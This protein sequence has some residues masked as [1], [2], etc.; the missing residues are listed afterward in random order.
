MWLEL[1]WNHCL[2]IA[3]H[4]P[5][6]IN[7]SRGSEKVLYLF[8]V[9]WNQ[10]WRTWPLTGLDIIDFLFRSTSCE[11]T[12]HVWNVPLW[13]LKK[14]CWLSERFEVQDWRPWLWLMEAFPKLLHNGVTRLD[15][16]FPLWVRNSSEKCCYFWEGFKVQNDH[17]SSDIFYFCFSQN[18]CIWYH[19]KCSSSGF[20]EELLLWVIWN[21][22]WLPWPLIFIPEPLHVLSCQSCQKCLS[23]SADLLLFEVIQD[24]KWPP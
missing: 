22:R 10:R 19:Q 1:L 14:Y 9:I 23:N 17:P 21:T 6:F 24:L 13:V 18:N 12:K 4:Q 8:E 16:S 5:S 3:N 7:S 15:R 20:E 11:V 2:P